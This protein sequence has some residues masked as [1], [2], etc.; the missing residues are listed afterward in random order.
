MLE[1]LRT[2]SDCTLVRLTNGRRYVLSLSVNDE[3]I[4]SGQTGCVTQ[5]GETERSVVSALR[6]L[7]ISDALKGTS[8]KDIASLLESV[9]L[10]NKPRKDFAYVA[11]WVNDDDIERRYS[12][13]FYVRS[14]VGNN[15]VIVTARRSRGKYT[16]G[17]VTRTE[18][19]LTRYAYSSETRCA[20]TFHTNE[21]HG[22]ASEI[23]FQCRRAYERLVAETMTFGGQARYAYSKE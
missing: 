11:N 3:L 6:N 16:I 4:V 7:V 22:G 14:R 23:G 19:D 15:V 18:Y 17:D 9:G 20:M 1:I 8:H 2:D 5:G 12:W 10:F 21:V 13:P